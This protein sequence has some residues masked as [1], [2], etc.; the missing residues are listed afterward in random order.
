MKGKKNISENHQRAFN[1]IVVLTETKLLEMEAATAKYEKFGSTIIQLENDVPGDV[2]EKVF[3]SITNIRR[4]LA[5]FSR[6]Y[7][8]DGGQKS[9]RKELNIKASFLWEDLAS[10]ADHKFKG[11]GPIDNDVLKEVT[12]YLD[13]LITQTKHIMALTRNESKVD[14]DLF[15]DG[16]SEDIE[17]S[18]HREV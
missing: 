7:D 17:L 9:L 18:D 8:L 5:R 13:D 6:E 12:G 3:E 4:T 10:A 16:L 14:G 11:Y 2:L 15:S 1:A